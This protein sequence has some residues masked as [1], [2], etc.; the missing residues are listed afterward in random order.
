MSQPAVS[1]A[2]ARLRDI[3]DDQ[4]FVRGRRGVEPTAKSSAM[5]APVRD[6][7]GLIERQLGGTQDVDPASYKR[8]F[9]IS[10]MDLLEP[11]VLPPLLNLIAERAPGVSIECV[12]TQPTLTQDIQAGTLDILCFP[13]PVISPDISIVAIGFVNPVLI[14]RRGHP[15]IVD[16]L[17]AETLKAL[18]FVVLS[19]ELRAVTQID[20]ELLVHDIKRRVVTTVARGWSMPSI[21]QDTDLVAVVPRA[22]ADYVARRFDLGIHEFPFPMSDQ[23]LYMMWNAKV[24]GDPAHKWLRE[25]LLTTGRQAL[26]VP[27]AVAIGKS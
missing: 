19:A 3:L 9:R 5:I 24:D 13:Y 10:A 20:R 1:N 18:S 15:L 17:D 12:L 16:S 25:I 11:L 2:L 26:G 27:K 7:L 6:A 14:A 22:F 4:L 21:V 8:M 23:H